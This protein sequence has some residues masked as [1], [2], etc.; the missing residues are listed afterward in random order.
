MLTNDTKF[1]DCRALATAYWEKCGFKEPALC[2]TVS[3]D[4]IY[5]TVFFPGPL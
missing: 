2:T 5:G 4:K 3:Y 1:F